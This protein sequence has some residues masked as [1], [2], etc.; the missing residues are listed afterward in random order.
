MVQVFKFIDFFSPKKPSADREVRAT[1]SAPEPTHALASPPLVAQT[2][3]E[4]SQSAGPPPL[5]SEKLARL[6]AMVADI[7]TEAGRADAWNVECSALLQELV[8]SRLSS[9]DLAGIL[10][11]LISYQ[12]TGVTSSDSYQSFISAFCKTSGLFQDMLHRCLF[13]HASPARTDSITSPYLGTFDGAERSAVLRRLRRE[14]YCVLPTRL[15]AATVARLNVAARQLSYRTKDR[16][17]ETVPEVLDG[18]DPFRPPQCGGAYASPDELL[19]APEFK[20]LMDDPLIRAL[21]TDYLETPAEAINATLWY[22]FSSKSA[23]SELAQLFHYDLDTIRWLKVFYYLNDVSEANGPHEYVEGSHVPGAKNMDLLARGYARIPD[24]DIDSMQ[25]GPV[26]SVVGPAGTVILGDTRAFHKGK[27][28]NSGHR[29]I[30]QPIYAASKI[31]YVP[32]L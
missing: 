8:T 13:P 24:D 30:F 28:V 26:R 7:P 15:D 1:P 4:Y 23:S 20:D 12:K 25:R 29:L 6:Q 10:A 21:A 32:G 3:P 2:V 5:N 11:G 27:L 17:S 9:A 22:S 18:V 19:S 14:G 31:N 16:F